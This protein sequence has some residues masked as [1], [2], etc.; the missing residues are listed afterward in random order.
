MKHILF[1]LA[2]LAAVIPGSFTALSQERP[3]K[4]TQPSLTESASLTKRAAVHN[5]SANGAQGVARKQNVGNAYVPGP[6][7]HSGTLSGTTNVGSLPETISLQI[8]PNPG[9]GV[10]TIRGFVGNTHTE[11][12][13]LT[14]SDMA[15]RVVYRSLA[16]ARNGII[17]SQVPLDN[18]LQTGMY[19]VELRAGAHIKRFN[20]VLQR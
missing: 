3:T 15:G 5:K 10:F 14:V 19:I 17:D 16:N 18:T 6:L 7:P 20:Y 2:I 4:N 11:E 13:T 12:T 9:A 8:Y 1:T